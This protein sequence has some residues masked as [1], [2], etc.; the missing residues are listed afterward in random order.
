MQEEQ[1]IRS[2]K[3]HYDKYKKS[4]IGGNNP[5]SGPTTSG[6]GSISI[7]K[8]N[9]R[10]NSRKVSVNG[11]ALSSASYTCLHTKNDKSDGS[12]QENSFTMLE[13]KT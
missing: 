11:K 5:G 10:S 9:S 1:I 8:R 3:Q 4:Q 13:S 12:E 2:I 6:T 7:A